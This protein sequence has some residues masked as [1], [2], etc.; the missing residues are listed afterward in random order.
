MRNIIELIKKNISHVMVGK[1]KAIDQLIIALFCNGHVLIE[2]VPGV[3]KTTMVWSLAKSLD[4]T[5]NRIQFTPDVLPSDITGYTMINMKTGESEFQQG[6]VMS[7]IIL[8]D[9]INRTPPKTQSALLEAM[10]ENQV[11]VDG[12]SYPTPQPFMV[13]ATQNPI[14]YIG[15]YPLPE[16]QL[17][18]FFMRISLGYP[19]A[20]QEMDIL[21]RFSKSDPRETLS[22]V[23]SAQHI[24][25]AQKEVSEVNCSGKI[26]EYITSISL[27]TRNEDQ[28]RLGVSPRGSLSL[29]QASKAKAYLAGRDFVIPDDVQEMVLPVLAHRIIVKP[30]AKLH[31]MNANRILSNIINAVRVP[32][33]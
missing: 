15:T 13:L 14:E 3:G 25:Q 21:H 18:R 8:A 11:T 23:T 10:Q 9:E 33:I 32:V 2:D 30:E 7:Q 12:K 27:R 26:Y 29:M 24:L 17:D 22:S 28:L 16:A 19:T 4:C 1:D 31:D 6:A 20:K 5:F